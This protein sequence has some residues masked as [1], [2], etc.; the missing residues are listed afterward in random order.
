MI[1]APATKLA[2]TIAAELAQFCDCIEIAG[3]IRRRRANV[4]DIDIVC[5]PKP[6]QREALRERCKRNSKVVTDGAQNLTVVLPKINFQLDLWIAT[7]GS[8]DMFD[9]KPCNFGS[10]LL[11]RTGSKDHNIW[12]VS[13]AAAM[14]LR[15]NPYWGVFDGHGKCL[16]AETEEDIFKTLKLDFIPPERRER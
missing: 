12:L 8:A 15:W 7:P 11:C 13:Q 2:G 4:N 10:L 16:A 3:S 9:P 5:L 14:G 1:L 6:D